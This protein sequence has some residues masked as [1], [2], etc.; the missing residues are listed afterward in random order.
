M[1]RDSKNRL[2]ELQEILSR[3]HFDQEDFQRLEDELAKLNAKNAEL[4][5]EKL[6]LRYRNLN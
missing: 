1:I 4:A 5:E 2:Q 3:K 6:K